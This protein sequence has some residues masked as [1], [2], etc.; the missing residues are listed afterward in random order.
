[1]TRE[2]VY[3]PSFLKKWE[4]LGLDEEDIRRLEEMLI[5]NPEL[6]DVIEGTGGIRKMRFA[7]RGKGKSGSTRVIYIDFQ[8]KEQIFFLD[9]YGKS[10]K[11]NLSKR[12]RN[13][14]R[15]LVELL[16]EQLNQG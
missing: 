15:C 8:T 16:E 6:G 11:G 9:I 1:M 12:E 3:I 10:E 13:E 2:F 4:K 5:A 14:L 7:F